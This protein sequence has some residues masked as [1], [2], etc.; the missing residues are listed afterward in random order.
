VQI[1]PAIQQIVSAISAML[2]STG[3]PGAA[4]LGLGLLG[5][6]GLGIWLRRAGRRRF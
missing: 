2:P 6:G 1:L 4:A 3:G 5:L